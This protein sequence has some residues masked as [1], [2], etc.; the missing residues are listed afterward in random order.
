M[1]TSTGVRDRA[2][3]VARVMW[4]PLA[5]VW[6]VLG[7]SWRHPIWAGSMIVLAFSLSVLDRTPSAVGV[8]LLGWALPAL[9]AVT[10][11]QVDPYSF[12]RWVGGPWRRRTWRVWVREHWSG[13]SR[14]CGLSTSQQAQRRSAWSGETKAV[15]V[16][17]DARLCSAST[18]G[19]TLTLTVRA[20]SGQTST[21]VVNAA[22]A[23]ASAMAADTYTA[24]PLTPSTASIELVMV[25][26]LAGTVHAPDPSRTSASAPVVVG[27]SANSGVVAFDPLAGLHMA[28]QGATRSGKSV[29]CYAY[30]SALAHRKD[31]LVCGV[32]PTGILLTPFTDGRGGSWVS[33]SAKDGEH[34]A[35]VLD[36]ITEQMDQRITDLVNGGRDKITTFNEC[37]PAILCV[38]E[39]YPGLLSQLA[40]DDEANGRRGKDRIAPQV[41]RA[42]GRFI[43]EG[44][45]VG[46]TVLILAQR[47]SA[48][49]IETDDRSNIPIRAT[50]RVDNGDAVA[51]LHDGIDR[52]GLDM[53]RQFPPG[54]GL[55]EA[56]GMPLQKFQADLIDYE[57]YRARVA[58]G[59][60]ATE[61][62]IAFRP[63]LHPGLSVVEGETVGINDSTTG[64]KAA[65]DETL[66]KAS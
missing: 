62:V 51:M 1:G 33:T 5:L 35:A 14:N 55:I 40:K 36:A 49:A 7:W 22:G 60:R 57:A 47:M 54:R 26:H 12:E 48:K 18:S 29:L 45:K 52:A 11:H 19:W 17:S 13:L 16:W 64:R 2:A 6:G 28:I 31:V 24:R 20:R 65:G 61:S 21:D 53:I 8:L 38:F 25:D 15:T 37:T 4:V 43:K 50:M 44:A 23:I 39:E 59:I 46:V 32:D 30:L 63:F 9:V 27:R 3:T 34:L 10:W 58:A 66:G 56:P 42:V 41:E